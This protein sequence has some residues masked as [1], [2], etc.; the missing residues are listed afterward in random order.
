MMQMKFLSAYIA[1]CKKD[2]AGYECKAGDNSSACNTGNRWN[3]RYDS[4]HLIE[5]GLRV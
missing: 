1:E 3:D 5:K 4:V 2:M